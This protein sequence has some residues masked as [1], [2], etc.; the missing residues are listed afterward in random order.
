MIQGNGN[1]GQIITIDK[2]SDLVLIATAG[3]YNSRDI[4]KQSDELYPDFFYPAI[5]KR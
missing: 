5:L 2:E 3:N 4:R 1:G